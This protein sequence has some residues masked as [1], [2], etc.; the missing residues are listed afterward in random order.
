MPREALWC[1]LKILGVPERIIDIVRSLHEGM[2]ARVRVDGVLLEEIAVNNGLRQ[3]C[4]LAP[5]LFNLHACLVAERW[6]SRM[7]DVEG[8]GTY[9][10]FKFNQRLFRRSTRNAQETQVTE[11]QFADDAALL[12]RTQTGAEKATLE[13]VQVFGLQASPENTKLMVVGRAAQDEDR[14]PIR[15]GD[16]EI[17]CVDEFTYE[18]KDGGRR[19]QT[20]CMHFQGFRRTSLCCLQRPTPDHYHQADGVPGMVLLYS[21]ECWTPLH[22]HVKH[23]NAFHHRCIRTTLGITN[24]QQWELRISCDMT[25]DL[26]GDIETAEIKVTKKRLERLGHAARMPEY[27]IPKMTLFGW[28][29]QRQPPGGPRQRWRDQSRLKAVGVDEEE[30]FEEASDRRG[31]RE[32]YRQGLQAR[33]TRQVQVST[34]PPQNQVLSQECGRSFRRAGDKA[35]HKCT[36]ERQK[37][38]Q[39]RGAAQCPVCGRWFRSPGG[40]AVH[41]FRT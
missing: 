30:W 28:L 8:A 35:R 13:Y 39:E 22:S 38:I 1:A 21:S 6:S 20:Y 12:A 23:L 24:R 18:W 10:R 16:G 27:R 36:T 11:C 17:E 3:G 4:T 7:A 33:C 9:L 15:V 19:G 29:P 34:A 37:P 32:P 14:T 26:W 5:V 2:K 31:W 25:R 41:D 40:L